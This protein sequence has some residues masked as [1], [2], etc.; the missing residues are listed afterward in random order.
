MVNMEKRAKSHVEKVLL[1]PIIRMH[2]LCNDAEHLSQTLW[3]W[4]FV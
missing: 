1:C 2:V 3:I 4:I